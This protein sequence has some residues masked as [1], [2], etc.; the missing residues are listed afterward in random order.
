MEPRTDEPTPRGVLANGVCWALHA[1]VIGGRQLILS[2][3]SDAHIA[4][5]MR[6]AW[7]DPR[8]V[9]ASPDAFNDPWT[10]ERVAAL[11]KPGLPWCYPAWPY[12]ADRTTAWLSAALAT[13]PVDDVVHV[14]VA[15]CPTCGR[16]WKLRIPHGT[17]WSM[18]DCPPHK[19][20]V[21]SDAKPKAVNC[22]GGKPT[23]TPAGGG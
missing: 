13:A 16:G 22:A 1:G 7:R 10:A 9:A 3:A 23:L 4:A 5:F 2:E 20:W 21:R 15:T 8:V 19:R 12:D 14:V 6:A 11:R 17:T 18:D